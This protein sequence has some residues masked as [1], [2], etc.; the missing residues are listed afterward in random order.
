MWVL[1]CV[2]FSHLVFSEVSVRDTEEEEEEK[3]FTR[4]LV[5]LAAATK[6][7]C[8]IAQ[9]RR[10]RDRYPAARLSDTPANPLGVVLLPAKEQEEFRFIYYNK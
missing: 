2:A 5:S 3:D 1:R 4:D 10:V 9:H 8:V 7:A 6:E